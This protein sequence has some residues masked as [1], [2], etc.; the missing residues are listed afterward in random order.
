MAAGLFRP[1]QTPRY[2]ALLT[3][4]RRELCAMKVAL[5]AYYSSYNQRDSSI[6]DQF[7]ICSASAFL[8][9]SREHSH[10]RHIGGDL[11]AEYRHVGLG[12]RIVVGAD[13]TTFP[14]TP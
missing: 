2:E 13:D 12:H 14:A 4:E 3:H 10:D 8:G 5:Y 6:A 11:F 7:R 9:A 1:R